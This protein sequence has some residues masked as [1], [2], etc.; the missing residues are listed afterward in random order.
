MAVRC[1]LCDELITAK[2]PGQFFPEDDSYVCALCRREYQNSL[3][4]MK[5]RANRKIMTVMPA[6][7]SSPV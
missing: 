7:V 5:N 1:N 2:N 3:E 6:L 4:E